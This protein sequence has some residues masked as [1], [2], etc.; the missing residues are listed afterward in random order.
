[1]GLNESQWNAYHV[2][3]ELGARK[4]T[5]RERLQQTM[6]DH[7]LRLAFA[8]KT[9]SSGLPPDSLPPSL[10]CKHPSANLRRSMSDLTQWTIPPCATWRQA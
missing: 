9:A 3:H 1:M 5:L 10:P 6:T 8:A 4:G 7:F 2:L